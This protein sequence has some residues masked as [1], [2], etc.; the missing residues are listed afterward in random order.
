[1]AE[2]YDGWVLKGPGY[3]YNSKGYFMP[4]F[5]HQTKRDVIKQV[6]KV[7]AEGYKKWR[8]GVGSGYKIVKV[9]LVEV[10]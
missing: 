6:D 10:E 8:K 2:K 9:K 5:F 1:M 7:V 3:S 4:S